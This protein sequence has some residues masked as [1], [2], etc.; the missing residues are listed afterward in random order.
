ML[1]EAIECLK[2]KSNGTY[3]DCT[4]GG[5]SH[6]QAILK[7][8]NDE[9]LLIGIDQ[10]SMAVD[11]AK[12]KL[13]KHANCIV[14]QSN[15]RFLKT[16]FK[17]TLFDGILFDLGCSTDQFINSNKG[18][19]FYKE[20][21]LDMRLDPDRQKYTAKDVLD[22]YSVGALEHVFKYLGDELHSK[23]IA[24]EIKKQIKSLNYSTD[25]ANLIANKIGWAKRGYHPATRIF[26]AL[27]MEVNNEVDNL[28]I[29]LQKAWDLL[30]PTGRIV[31]I[32]FSPVEDRI[33][34][35]FMINLFKT[36]QASFVKRIIVDSDEIK[37]NVSARS[38]K[39]RYIEKL[40]KDNIS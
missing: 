12:S 29:G 8:L 13:K 28:R 26:Q 36:N 14:M 11:I 31:V 1:K 19:S 21:P 15:F 23:S 32:T 22:N 6:A 38:A 7:L 18:L 2:I 9:G 33:V 16:L 34:K 25:L 39:I 5:A 40:V 20:G 24:I 30:K 17:G 37:V 35:L 4:L 27:R 10:D 3:L